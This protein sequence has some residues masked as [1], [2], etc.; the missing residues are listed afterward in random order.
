MERTFTLV[1][2]RVPERRQGE[3]DPS[4]WRVA[5]AWERPG[6]LGRKIAEDA[7]TLLKSLDD[8]EEA[9]RALGDL[10]EIVDA[11]LAYA[12]LSLDDARNRATGARPPSKKEKEEEAKLTLQEILSS[13]LRK[14]AA[15][16][17]AALAAGNGAAA[18]DLG[19]LLRT[20]EGLAKAHG[21]SLARATMAQRAKR[22]S[23]GGYERWILLGE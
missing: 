22:A 15:G 6:L 17:D 10:L 13:R 14:I 1:R 11:A 2:D 7:E 21:L 3:I 9:E 4:Q 12:G 5:A 20:A 19:N 23:H 16:L 8:F 18:P